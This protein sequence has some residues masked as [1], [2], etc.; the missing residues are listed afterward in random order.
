MPITP[1][2]TITIVEGNCA[3]RRTMSSESRTE[4][5]RYSILRRVRRHR[6]GRDHDCVRRELANAGVAQVDGDRVRVDEPRAAVEDVNP[7]PQELVADDLAF[8]LDHVA[9]P[10]GD[11]V[12]RDALAQPVALSVNRALVEPRQVQDR[13]ADRLRRDRPRVHARTAERDM[14]LDER[15]VLPELGCLDRGLLPR[16]PRPHD[17]E[18][19]LAHVLSLTDGYA[20]SFARTRVEN[21]S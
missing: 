2:P 10:H 13:L 7:V 20:E 9:C 4:I 6:P 17:H 21:S 1:A 16:R 12:D 18:V 3:S 8:T 15:H 14:A 5:P 19:E 11:V